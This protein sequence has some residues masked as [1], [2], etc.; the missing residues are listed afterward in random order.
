MMQVSRQTSNEGHKTCSTTEKRNSYP[1]RKEYFK[2]NKGLFGHIWFCSQCGKPLFGKSNIVV[3]HIM[4]L[5]HGGVNR[6][7]NCVAICEKCN[8]KKGAK[9]DHRVLKGYIAKAFQSS[10]FFTQ[11]AIGK[12]IKLS[13]KGAGYALSAP[14]RGTTGKVKVIGAVFYIMVF[15][16]LG[17]YVLSFIS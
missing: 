9:V 4:P 2:R 17:R 11:G 12:V 5:K 8:A 13:A 10:L 15:I 6:T 3:D 14:F 16:F 7:F 1:Y